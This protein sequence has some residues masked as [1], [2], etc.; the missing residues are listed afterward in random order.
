MVRQVSTGSSADLSTMFDEL[1]TP[2]CDSVLG[3]IALL[4]AVAFAGAVMAVITLYRR[5]TLDWRDYS[6]LAGISVQV[7]WSGNRI[8]RRFFELRQTT[9]FDANAST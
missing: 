9:V 8:V 7:V 3:A 4:G 2:A 5:E 6:V 1:I